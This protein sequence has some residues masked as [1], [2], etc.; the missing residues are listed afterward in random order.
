M[1]APLSAL[2]V[3]DV[4]LASAKLVRLL[5]AHADIRVDGTARSVAEADA[6]LKAR[7]FDLLLLDIQLPDGDGMALAARWPAMA[8]RTI[9][10]TAHHQHALRS[11]ALGAADYLLKPV[12]ADRLAMALDRTRRLIAPPPPATSGEGLAVKQGSRTEFLDPAR[13]DYIDMA[14]HYA[15]VHVG[16]QVHLLRESITELAAQLGG[17]GL[18][19]VHRSVLV[20][21]QRVYALCERRNGDAMLELAG[22]VQL[23]LSRTYRKALEDA[24]RAR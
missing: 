18:L 21:P 12:D 3:E 10:I 6:L 5:D 24:L 23:P 4:P 14:G 20:N 7:R 16:A 17:A 19:R 22:G 8:T 1:S 15:C 13:I 11:Y 9:F 2:V